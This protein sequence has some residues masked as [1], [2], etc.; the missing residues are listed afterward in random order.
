T[1]FSR[2]WSSDVCSS[3]LIVLSNPPYIAYEEM[4]EMSD[5]VVAHEPHQALF[6]DED[7]LLLYRKLAENLP[8]LMKKPALIGLEI[9]Y[10]QGERS[11]QRR[12]GKDHKISSI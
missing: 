5:V 10:T 6:A 7:G 3:D 12:V 8:A 1:R 11:E 9:G 2:D 4:K